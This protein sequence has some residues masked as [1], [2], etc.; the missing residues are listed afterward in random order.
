MVLAGGL[1]LL[2]RKRTGDVFCRA[3][4]RYESD[5]HNGLRIYD[6]QDKLIDTLEAGTIEGW[7]V[8]A[9]DGQIIARNQPV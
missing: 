4:G 6:E 8:V 5:G 2:I 1:V 3:T 7:Q 9:P